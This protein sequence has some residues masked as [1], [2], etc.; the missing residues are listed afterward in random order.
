M[1]MHHS[2]SRD[3]RDVCKLV[4]YGGFKPT[5]VWTMLK[6]TRSVVDHTGL[7]NAEHSITHK[8]FH[9]AS[10]A[11]WPRLECRS[12]GKKLH[13]ALNETL[14][15]DHNAHG[16]FKA[17]LLAICTKNFKPYKKQ[18]ISK[19]RASVRRLTSVRRT[20]G[21]GKGISKRDTLYTRANIRN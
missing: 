18:Q 2:L 4:Y 10:I 5:V 21:T 19:C 14:D 20:K 9:L 11:Q 17:H 12:G 6:T 15:F 3:F 16:Q 13:S 8:K 1:V 7:D